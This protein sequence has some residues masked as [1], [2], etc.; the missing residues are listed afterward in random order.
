MCEFGIRFP[1]P[2][3]VNERNRRTKRA[4]RPSRPRT[5]A[6]PQEAAA[7]RV[8]EKSWP[9][10]PGNVTSCR[11]NL[12]A[13]SPMCASERKYREL[14]AAGAPAVRGRKEP[15]VRVWHPISTARS[16]EKRNR[17]TRRAPRPSRPRTSAVPQEAA[18]QRV[19]E[20]S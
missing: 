19:R 5:P 12:M 18:A 9:G 20:K 10:Q 13:R 14:A 8:R 4:P 1:P 17:R 16:G 15:R 6:V 11:A 2:G 3:A 7:Q